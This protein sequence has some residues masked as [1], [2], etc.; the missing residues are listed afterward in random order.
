MTPFKGIV[1]AASRDAVIRTVY[2]EARGEGSEGQAAVAWVIR[3]RASRPAWWG[4]TLYGVCHRPYQF[5]CWN[6]S[7][8]NAALLANLAENDPDYLR[9][10]VVVDL[11]LSGAT[12]D[13]TGEATHYKVTGTKASWDTS[14][15]L[16]TEI[17][18]GRHSFC[19]LGPFA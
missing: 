17:I 14:A 8:P 4:S 1:S 6:A 2:G 10:G 18:I 19:K 3:N 13:P 15:A 11:V 5:S 9:I 7:D 12:P 16:K